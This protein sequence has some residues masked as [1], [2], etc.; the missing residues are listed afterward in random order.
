MKVDLAA[1]LIASQSTSIGL[2]RAIASQKKRL[3]DIDRRAEA[4]ALFIGHM[5]KWF[6]LLNSRTR[7]KTLSKFNMKSTIKKLYF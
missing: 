5:D 1:Q 3:N 2:Y 7:T 4:T 6:D